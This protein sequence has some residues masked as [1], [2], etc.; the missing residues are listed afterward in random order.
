[1]SG[2]VTGSASTLALGG[3]PQD[4]FDRGGAG[5]HFLRAAKPQGFHAILVRIHSQLVQFALLGNLPDQ[6]AGQLHDFIHAGPT[7]VT[8]VPALQAANRVVDL[9]GHGGFP[10]SGQALPGLRVH[11]PW[12]LA[13]GAQGSG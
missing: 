9:L 6:V 3:Y 1:M 2:M 8:G 13:V 10:G 7:I 4:F 5:G 11:R 12:R